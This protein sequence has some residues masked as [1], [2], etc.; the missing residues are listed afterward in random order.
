MKAF[1]FLLRREFWENRGAFLTLPLGIGGFIVFVTLLI[2]TG[3]ATTINKID[4]EKFLLTKAVAE[5]QQ[6]DAEKL[7]IIWTLNLFGTAAIFNAVLLFVVFFYMLGALPITVS[8]AYQS[9]VDDELV[10]T[11]RGLGMFVRTGA[12]LALLQAEREKFLNREWPQLAA[13]MARLGLDPA[14]LIEAWK[15]DRNQRGN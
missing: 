3:A 14:E 4:G 11:R 10:E 13:K 5:I 2:V 15:A 9:L 8:K 12:K 7:D 6:L 1:A